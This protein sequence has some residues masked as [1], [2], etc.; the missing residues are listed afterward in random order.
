MMNVIS[1]EF[2]KIFKS[3]IF[4]VISIILLAMNGLYLAISIFSKKS[5][6]VS[7]ESQTGIYSYQESYNA[8][9]I[10][11]IIILF[12]VFL[13]TS[14]YTNGTIR[15]MTC[16]GIARWKLILGQYIA[17]SAAITIVL[18]I[19]GILNLLVDTILYQF[20]EFDEVAFIQMNIGLIFMFW[21]IAGI[22]VVISHLFKS[23]SVAVIISTLLI[24]SKNLIAELLYFITENSIFV[25]YNITSMRDTIINFA[26]KP[27]D[28]MKCSIVFL[29]IGI[30][31]I[32]GANLIFYKRDVD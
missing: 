1:S 20:G 22:G 24:M 16:H 11:Y 18:L 14:E 29:L 17:I 2:Y 9:Y 3:R 4:Y 28:V 26:S 15:Q 12:V 30:F 32:L 27:E 23:G 5:N 25:R 21:G 8:D 13:I 19:F 10:F 31:T 6:S 7:L